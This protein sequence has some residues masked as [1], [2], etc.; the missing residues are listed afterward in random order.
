MVKKIF[1]VTVLLFSSVLLSG[2][3]PKKTPEVTVPEPEPTPLPTRPIE[4]TIKERPYV[5]LTSTSDGHWVT[6]EIKRISKEM[7]GLEYELTYFA[8]VEASKIER[9]VSSGGQPVE[10]NG[11][12]EFSKKILF[13]SASCTTG[14]CKYKYDE[15]VSEGMLTVKLRSKSGTE[16]YD[17]AY[18]IQKG[19]EAKE[20]FGVGDGVFAFISSSL[21]ANTLYLTISTIGVPSSLPEGVVA[22][23]VPYGIFPAVSGKGTVTFK[24]SLAAA[25]IYAFNGKI[26][27]KL[28]TTVANGSATA[29]S[30]GASIFILTE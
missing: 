13:G 26:W 10:L 14:T 20:G 23:T 29:E 1:I 16:K 17:S 9:G 12:T 5:T 15:N 4:Q 19:K 21:P 2:C 7:T 28:A 11:A 3:G 6:L 18:R 22:K 30:S 8:E 25:N 27:T 24:T